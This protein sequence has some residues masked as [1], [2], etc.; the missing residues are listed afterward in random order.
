[1]AAGD[2]KVAY[3]ASANL[4]VTNLASIATSATW[5]AGWTSAYIDN[6]SNLYQDYLI[7]GVI[8]VG[9]DTASTEVRIYLYAEM[10]DST[11]PDVF[12]SGTE[13]TE[14]TATIRD[15]NTR[16]SAFVLAHVLTTSGTDDEVYPIRPFSVASR[17]GGVCPRK[18]ALFVTHNTGNNLYASGHQLTY[19]GVYYTVA[20]S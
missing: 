8:K 2:V 7:T 11:A 6:S 3:A 17:F 12:S 1:M 14:G 16:E 9:T 19:K 13:G 5:V 20:Q 15:T 4:T 10:D 18:F